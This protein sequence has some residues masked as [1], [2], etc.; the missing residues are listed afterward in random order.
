MVGKNVN[1]YITNW[2]KVGDTVPVDKWTVDIEINWINEQSELQEHEGTYT[3]P[4]ILGGIP[5]SRMRKY[6][7]EL[8]LREAR[9]Q[10]GVD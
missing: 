2:Q 10:L 8:V 1:V 9:I 6:M 7:E 4:N 3:F 5:L